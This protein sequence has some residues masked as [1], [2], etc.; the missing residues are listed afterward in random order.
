MTTTLKAEFEQMQHSI[1]EV[2]AA[3]K[4]ISQDSP[5][6]GDGAKPT[7]TPLEDQLYIALKRCGSCCCQ[8]EGKAM[9][10]FKAQMVVAK[11]CSLCKAVAAYK[12]ANGQA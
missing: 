4:I 12:A 8:M 1:P 9:W 10:H 11:Q 3:L 7:T 6:I 5:L 2:T